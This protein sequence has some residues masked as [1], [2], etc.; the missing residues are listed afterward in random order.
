[1]RIRAAT[2]HDAG[3][4]AAS[5]AAAG[6][7]PLDAEGIH[8]EHFRVALHDAA[9]IGVAGLERYGDDGLLRSLAVA[10]QARGCGTGDAL[11][12]ALEA[13]AC[14]L[15][16]HSLVLLTTTAEAYFQRRGYAVIARD[17]MPTAVQRSSEFSTL[18]PASAVCMRK[19]LADAQRAGTAA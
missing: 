13:H 9:V 16:L 5:L 7:P 11:I 19:V 10:P 17:A 4:I 6:L 1:M 15:G 8:A 2:A 14:A 3:T 12:G 18:C